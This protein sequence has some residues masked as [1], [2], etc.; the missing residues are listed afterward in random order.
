[1]QKTRGE[2]ASNF[3][4]NVFLPSQGWPAETAMD[5]VTKMRD[6]DPKAFRKYFAELLRASRAGS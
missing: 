6:L 1:M 2:E 4:V 3:F 5:F